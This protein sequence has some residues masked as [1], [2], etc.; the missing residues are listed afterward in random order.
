MNI[1][2]TEEIEENGVVYI[3]E[4]F[5]NGANV[6]RIKSTE[7]ERPEKQYLSS[8]EESILET[9]LNTEYLVCL[10]ELGL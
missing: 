2:S 9:A 8:T 6:K 3:I 10:A 1:I 4:T 5:S 7:P